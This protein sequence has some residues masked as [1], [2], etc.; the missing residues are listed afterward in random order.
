[1][2]NQARVANV[3]RSCLV[4]SSFVRYFNVRLRERMRVGME[5]Q[6]RADVLP[7]EASSSARAGA[8]LKELAGLL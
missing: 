5:A 8:G 6:V 1:M 4:C 7:L 2:R 3:H